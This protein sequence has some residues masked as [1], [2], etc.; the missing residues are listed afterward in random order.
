MRGAAYRAREICGTYEPEGED[1]VLFT[2]IN[3]GQRGVPI[4]F[5]D[6]GHR[7]IP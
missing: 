1:N 3:V 2:I 6:C 5:A 4:S 7:K